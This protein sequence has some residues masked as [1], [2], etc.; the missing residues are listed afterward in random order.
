M[1]V[2][3]WGP[4]RSPKT[5]TRSG[6][7]SC[8]FRKK[9][10]DG[11]RPVCSNCWI[12]RN[13]CHWG[14]KLSFHPSR[15]LSLSTREAADLRRV[16]RQRRHSASSTADNFS[17]QFTVGIV[18]IDRMIS[19]RLVAW[20]NTTPRLSMIPKTSS[21]HSVGSRPRQPIFLSRLHRLPRVLLAKK[22]IPC[23]SCPQV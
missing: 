19:L 23:V 22:S 5:R 16:E 17:S 18:G 4:S 6:C 1:D 13:V 12:R 3:A 9:K 7:L 15:A 2:T 11:V 14:L 8:R 20:A 10:C 21:G